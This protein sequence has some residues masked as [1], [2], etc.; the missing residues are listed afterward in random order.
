ML[1]NKNSLKEGKD[2][3]FFFTTVVQPDTARLPRS[4]RQTNSPPD[5]QPDANKPAQTL[6]SD[7]EE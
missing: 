7:S 2:N 6:V 3:D 1:S 4:G 5:T